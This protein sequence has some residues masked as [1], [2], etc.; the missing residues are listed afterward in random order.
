MHE[1]GHN[2]DTAGRA[3]PEL[4]NNILP[5]YMATVDGNVSR[6][7]TDNVWERK[8]YPKVTKQDYSDNLW[9]EESGEDSLAQLSPLWQLNLYT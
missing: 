8:I 3:M 1:I 7:T 4:T 9:Q 6:I 5:I 2:M